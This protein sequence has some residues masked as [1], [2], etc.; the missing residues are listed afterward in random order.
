MSPLT[1]TVSA[2]TIFN[3]ISGRIKT[4]NVTIQH[5]IILI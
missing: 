1:K 2:K 5:K 4:L 3:V